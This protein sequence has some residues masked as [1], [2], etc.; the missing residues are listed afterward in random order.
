MCDQLIIRPII[1]T[2]IYLITAKS[3]T[4]RPS[5]THNRFEVEILKSCWSKFHQFYQNRRRQW[6]FIIKIT[7][8]TNSPNMSLCDMYYWT[9]LWDDN[10]DLLIYEDV[11]GYKYRI[12]SYSFLPW[13][14]SSPL[15]VSSSS[16]E[17]IQIFIS[18]M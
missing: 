5:K 4:K 11:K 1:A 14:V 17:T 12:S 10:A 2:I 3:D 9:L 15:I 13:I 6:F 18:L 8:S 7:S 16:E